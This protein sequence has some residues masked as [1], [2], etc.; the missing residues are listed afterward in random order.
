MV[1]YWFIASFLPKIFG[2]SGGRGEKDNFYARW[3]FNPWEV[4]LMLTRHLTDFSI[5]DIL[6]VARPI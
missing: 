5:L 3:D 2:I 1:P 6:C 4:R